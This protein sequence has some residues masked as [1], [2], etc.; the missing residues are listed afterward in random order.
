[1]ADVKIDL[2]GALI[3]D[4]HTASDGP[5]ARVLKAR[6][7]LYIIATIASLQYYR[8]ID[9]AAITR[10]TGGL[11]KIPDWIITNSLHAALAVLW[12]QFASLIVQ[13]GLSYQTIITSRLLKNS[14]DA[15]ERERERL[16]AAAANRR[17]T[18]E[19]LKKLRRDIESLGHQLAAKESERGAPNLFRNFVVRDAENRPNILSGTLD[20]TG[21][22]DREIIEIRRTQSAV[23]TKA[24]EQ[25][26]S[27]PSLQEAERAA[28]VA[29]E[30]QIASTPERN[31]FYWAAE[32]VID[33]LRVG[34]PLAVASIALWL[35]L[36]GSR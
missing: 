28:Q 21:D 7:W 9:L 25:E 23:L 8:M 34:A 10:L 11:F 22:V 15:I 14:A 1:M 6:K 32:V 36:F 18:E 17:A 33:V 2:G 4:E 35:A 26:T 13:L 5:Y 29:Y 24:A 12:L 19:S 20:D 16:N 30:R 31:P 27:L 3:D